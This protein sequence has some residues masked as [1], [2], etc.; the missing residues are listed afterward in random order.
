MANMGTLIYSAELI[1]SF[2]PS[3]GMWSHSG[4]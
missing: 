3:S 4:I 2:A 1:E